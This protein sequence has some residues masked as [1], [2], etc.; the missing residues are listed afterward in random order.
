MWHLKRQSPE[1]EEV[2]KQLLVIER[3][4]HARHFKFGVV[5]VKHGQ[6]SDVDYFAN[7]ACAQT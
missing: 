4:Q 2:A 3:E 6:T 1:F 7:G 5:Y